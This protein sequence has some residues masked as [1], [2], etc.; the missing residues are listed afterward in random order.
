MMRMTKPIKPTA[1]MPRR[2]IFMESQTSS[3]P[4]FVASLIVLAACVSQD[5]MPMFYPQM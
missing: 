2:L 3:L 5:R 1:P 4:G